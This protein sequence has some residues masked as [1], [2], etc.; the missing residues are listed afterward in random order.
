MQGGIKMKIRI[1]I[2]E[3][4]EG[5]IFRCFESCPGRIGCW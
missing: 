4:G 2:E 1:K 3:C 5:I